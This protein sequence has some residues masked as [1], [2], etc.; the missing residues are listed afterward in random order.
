MPM[1]RK[2]LPYERP[3][4]REHLLALDGHDRLMRFQCFMSN[5]AVAAYV[6]GIDLSKA[7]LVG[8]FDGGVLRGVAEVMFDRLLLPAHAEVGLSVQSDWQKQGIGAEL[9]SRAV[10]LARNRGAGSI[11]LLCLR[12]NRAMQRI[13]RRLSG[14]LDFADCEVAARVPLARA[15]PASIWL[16]AVQDVGSWMVLFGPRPSGMVAA[17]PPLPSSRLLPV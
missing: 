3:L 4:L 10:M 1:I 2:L 15:T 5:P 11:H 12:E 7:I 9:A 13:A 14:L 6:D 16:E 8:W 17:A